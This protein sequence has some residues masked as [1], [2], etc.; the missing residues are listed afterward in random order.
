MLKY[1]ENDK[2]S[3]LRWSV[4]GHPGPIHMSHAGPLNRVSLL[5]RAKLL[6]VSH[7]VG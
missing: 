2:L 5:C 7:E 6:F 4:H 1:E 3:Q